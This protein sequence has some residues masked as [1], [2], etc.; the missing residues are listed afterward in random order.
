MLAKL[1]VALLIGLARGVKLT[2][3]SGAVL[4]GE[5]GEMAAD[6]FEMDRPLARMAH[7]HA[8]QVGSA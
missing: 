1:V 4:V 5:G 6:Q 7:P 2:L 3:E 8:G